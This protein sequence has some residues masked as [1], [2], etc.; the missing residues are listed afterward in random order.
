M[1]KKFTQ[2]VKP[3][4]TLDGDDRFIL[5]NYN[6]AKPFSN[7]FPGVAGIWGVPMWVFY[8][9][10]GQ[11]ISSF[12]IEGKNKS[13]VEFLPANKAY[14]A[15]S[16]HGFRTFVKVHS[17]STIIEW[18]PFQSASAQKFKVSQNMQMTSH[19]LTIEEVNQTLGVVCR[20]NYFTMPEE[21]FPALVRRVT[22][23]NISKKDLTLQVIDGLP[24]FMPYGMNDW[25]IKNMSRT[26][27]AWIK[28]RNLEN[29]APYYQLNVEVDDTPDV[30]HIKEGNF[31]F[32]FEQGKKKI[33]PAIAQAE[34]VFGQETDFLMPQR[35]FGQN[36]FRIPAAQQTS[37]RTPCAM[38]LLKCDLAPK[39]A[40]SF[41]SVI[42]HAHS[43]QQLDQIITKST[44]RHYIEV[45]DQQNRDIISGIK[46]YT[47][48][49]S[50]SRVFD[51]CTSQMFLDNVLR[52]GLPVSLKTKDG[53]IAF[54]VFSRKHGD[55]ERDYN[56]FVL[57]PTYFSQGNGN[58]RD[59]NQNRRNDIWFNTDVADS[60]IVTFFNL[61]Q[62]DGYNPLIVKGMSFF[63]EDK[64]R[65][66][67][68][69]N[70]TIKGGYDA[71]DILI[72]N[73]F[74]PGE[75]LTALE[76]HEIKLKTS[77]QK[78][79]EKILSV[80]RKQTLADHGE[81]FWVDH[82]TY[83]ID[84]LESYLAVFPEK[85]HE[86]LLTKK[87]FTFFFNDHYV[88]P[89]DQRYLLTAKGVR[90]YHSVAD[91]SKYI[92][93][94]QKGNL[95]RGDEGEGEVYH[96]TL[97][98]KLLCLIANKA[99]TFDPDGIGI[100]MEADKPGWCDALNGLPGLLGSSIC[101]VFELQRYARFLLDAFDE[102]GIDDHYELSVLEELSE[103]I[104]ELN[105]I[106][107]SEK[108][109]LR[110]W[111]KANDVKESYRLSIRKG[112]RGD[113]E[114]LPI[115]DIRDFLNKVIDRTQTAAEKAK[116]AK[117]LV[118]TYF[119]YEVVEYDRL[120][121]EH[122]GRP[123]VMPK[124]FKGRALPLFLEGIVHALRVERDPA[125]ARKLYQAV[126]SSA[127]FDKELKMYKVSADLSSENE[128]IGR[129][130]V[131]PRGWLENESIWI[132]MEYKY[133]LELLRAGLYREFY[134]TLPDVLIPFLKP[135]IYGRSTLE[136]SSFIVSSAHED[137]SLH[138]QGFVARLSG[139]TAEFVHMWLWMNIGQN[140]FLMNQQDEL[141]LHLEP[142]LARE[143]FTSKKIT[144]LRLNKEGK[145][146]TLEFP[147][148][149]Y[150][151]HFLASTLVVYHNP[152]GLDI[153]PDADYQIE[154]I[155][156]NYDDKKTVCLTDG[157]IPSPYARDVRDG[158]VKRIDVN[159]I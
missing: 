128:D 74:Q 104:K 153:F 63:A 59:V 81:G 141:C 67:D 121:E 75:L 149:S 82:W 138:G 53:D 111:N 118:A 88:L 73:G 36:S 108:D 98:V 50:A 129:I 29:N 30:R 40:K 22:F 144:A 5:E 155:T 37:N 94:K 44:A 131:F 11:C 72:E 89:R 68:I 3:N 45:K 62:A 109:P 64:K 27:E 130:R 90:Q 120:N 95:L 61:S 154:R 24:M 105:G 152:K 32:S 13:M 92:P 58:F 79:L 86:L 28:V 65:V 23:E 159:F 20:V 57:A 103:F 113:D 6:Q 19:D 112:I 132:H 71:L 87:V 69:L 25:V 15:T 126:R 148:G 140:P 4:Y 91:G 85:L 8:V 100:E 158:K 99:A 49:A 47:F 56:Y 96:T 117:G 122:D 9:N 127:L 43:Q 46:N 142:I 41:I 78:F 66:E 80:C 124:K 135:E 83:N 134:D 17:G 38:T 34:C 26:V 156:L 54:N 102:L 147:Q 119:A 146:E 110:Y 51:Q 101:E 115:G 60:S 93:A 1:S 21:N 125:R 76:K 133:L 14:W 106:L 84:L 52:G 48:T 35:F 16:L 31:Y 10:R 12:G 97:I 107:A 137:P 151:F 143:M 18:E 150:A 116:N 123:F 7:F 136:N 33:L 139:S 2:R 39:S 55:P 77:P 157:F 145:R 70:E 114:G 42:G